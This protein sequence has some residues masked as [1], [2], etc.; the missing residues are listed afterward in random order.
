MKTNPLISVL[1]PAFNRQQYI[2]EAINA[3]LASTFYNFELIIVD[4]HSIDNTLAI[5]QKFAARDERIRVYSNAK[6]L[7]QFPNRNKAASLVK[8]S[9]IFCADSD[10][11]IEPD[12]L[13]YVADQFEAHPQI[14]FATMYLLGD[15]KK[16]TVV[17]SKEAVRR[18]FLEKE[19]LLI[20][21]A[22]TII[23]KD[24]FDSIGGFPEAYGPA[25]DLY[26]NAKAA[27]NSDVLLLPYVFFKYRLHEGQEVNKKY[28]YLYNNYKY[29]RDVMLLPEMPLTKEERAD[30]Q[31]KN[32]RNFLIQSAVYFKNSFNLGETVRAYKLAGFGWKEFWSGIYGTNPNKGEA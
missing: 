13:Q 18:N 29:L 20:G 21:P 27:C 10:D 14:N 32:N 28:E 12:A 31:T 22:G 11:T 7:E 5:A 6:N 24:F 25:G 30:L 23:R 2:E 19:F 8:G 16:P 26:Y 3:V 1:M 17:S 15:I 9:I 4:D